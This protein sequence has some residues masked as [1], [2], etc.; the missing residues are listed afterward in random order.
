MASQAWTLPGT[1]CVTR[2][3][4]KRPALLP[5]IQHL[6]HR[7][8]DG[9]RRVVPVSN[10]AS[11]AGVKGEAER[12]LSRSSRAS[13]SSRKLS[14]LVEIPLEINCLYRLSAPPA[15]AVRKT[16]SAGVR[17]DGRAHVAAVGHQAGQAA[18]VQLQLVQGPA[19]LRDGR[20]PGRLA[21]P[22]PPGP[23]A[24]A[25]V[26][27]AQKHLAIAETQLQR[28]ARWRPRPG[29][30]RGSNPARR[31]GQTGHPVKRAGIQHA[32]SPGALPTSSA[33]VPL[34]E[35]VGPS[36]VMTGMSGGR[37]VT[38]PNRVSK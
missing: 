2:G 20:P 29:H 7:G 1:S 3:A 6:I 8:F 11:C 22:W 24:G 16:L 13:R 12:F 19:H 5:P 30:R 10:C 32:E 34:P 36:M 35:A 15:L 21:G 27:L 18:E 28:R 33:S 14:I 9:Q 38:T 37:A 31:V 26:F 25:D 17:E 4:S 23:Q